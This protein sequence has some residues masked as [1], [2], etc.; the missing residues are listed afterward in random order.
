M[1][2]LIK[3]LLLLYFVTNSVFAQNDT[4]KLTEVEVS[5]NR[6]SLPFS[7]TS[8]T[9]KIIT[10]DDI[11]NALATNVADLLQQV[12]GIDVRRRG[13]DGMQSDLYIRGGNFD[14]TLILIDGV[15][16]D[17][18]QTGH[19]SMNAILPLENIER[20]EIIK[21]PAARVFGQNAFTGAINI[22]TKKISKNE[23]NLKLNYGSYQNKKGI[24]SI[25]QKYNNGDLYASV[26][27]QKSDG[28]RY[29][30]DFENVNSFLK[31]SFSNYQLITSFAQRKFGANGF[32][33]S[34][35]YT[36]QYEE[37]QTSLLAVSSKYTVLSTTI[38]PR[39][40]WRRNQDMYLFLRNNPA[41]YRNL[42][43]SNKLGAETNMVIN[44]NFGKTGIG[45]DVSRTFLLSNNL[46]NHNRTVVTG[47]MEH[48][49][50]IK[51]K[52]DITPGIAIS[53]Y[54]DFNTNAFPGLA[55]GYRISNAIKI[56]SNIGY[57][58]RV[59]TFTDMFYVGPTTQGNPDLEPESAL[60]EE[61]GLNYNKN[62]FKFTLALFNRNSNN[63]IDWTKQ[64]EEDKWQTKNFSKVITKG[65]ET[66]ATYVFKM[67]NF[68]QS[69]QFGYNY[70]NDDIRDVNVAYTRYSLNSIKHQL[71]SSFQTKFFNK[72][73]Q[74]ISYRYVE[75][76]D[77]STYNIVDAKISAIFSKKIKMS[78]IANN[79]F[80]AVYTE[81]NLVPMPKGNL[82]VSINYRLY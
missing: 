55:I 45:L 40:Y 79:I 9:I 25:S 12:V 71:T 81:T 62:N 54:S 23:L 27:F 10:K 28:Y 21:G 18:V 68:N 35:D 48:R 77:G 52:L 41:Y 82:M 15:K 57:T 50:E 80:N 42:H 67:N 3:L 65:F 38:K 69:L 72:I 46:G 43:I 6:I 4:I 64:N 44:S 66:S 13:I 51:N 59:P 37:T 5:S 49:F 17:D 73:S 74:N 2:L 34:P 8:H 53:Y 11:N 7:K 76:T 78:V 36:D 14:Q 47:F 39:I 20:I 16:M 70:V 30:T 60:S 75:R 24:A 26:G 61:I 56:Y 63:L 19:H 58:Y 29:N 31:S 22:V 33:A 1:K 32:Y